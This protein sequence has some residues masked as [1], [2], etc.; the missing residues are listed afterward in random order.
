MDYGAY[1]QLFP[2]SLE[3]RY[4]LLK[5][6]VCFK[7]KAQFCGLKNVSEIVRTLVVLNLT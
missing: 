1:P 2:K 3:G 5:L 4:I 6:S 7:K